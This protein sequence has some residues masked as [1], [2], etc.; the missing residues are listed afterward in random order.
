MAPSSADSM[1]MVVDDEPMIRKMVAAALATSG[2][3]V[4]DAETP[5][6]AIRMMDS[7]PA[8]DLLVTDIVMPEVDGHELAERMRLKQPALKVLFM[9]GFEPENGPRQL[10]QGSDFL[11]KPFRITDLLDRVKQMLT[12]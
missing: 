5:Q 1:V 10:A 7:H 9:S 6:Q 8:L 11:Q 12:D 4:V 3:R 2:Y